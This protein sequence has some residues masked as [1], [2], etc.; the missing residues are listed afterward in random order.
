MEVLSF[1]IGLSLGLYSLSMKRFMWLIRV[2]A[3]FG[4]TYIIFNILF[5]DLYYWNINEYKWGN[6]FPFMKTF[7]FWLDIGITVSVIGLFYWFIPLLLDKLIGNKLQKWYESLIYKI[8]TIQGLNRIIT[9]YFS[10]LVRSYIRLLI[11]IRFIIPK[12][13]CKEE[14]LYS[15]KEF[16]NIVYFNISLFIEIMIC[17][18]F[19]KAENV[20]IIAGSICLFLLILFMIITPFAKYYSKI[21]NDIVIREYNCKVE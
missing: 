19:I 2:I 21:S 5:P 18:L 20:L 7:L 12:K 10:K 11:K 3:S 1:V 8:N 6:I 17:L 9:I 14:D 13:K 4:I 15:Y 16:M